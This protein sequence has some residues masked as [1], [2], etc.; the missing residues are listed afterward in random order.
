MSANLR[1]CFPT[2]D[3]ACSFLLSLGKLGKVQMWWDGC[4]L[5]WLEPGNWDKC[6]ILP[7]KLCP[8]TWHSWLPRTHCT[9]LSV[10]SGI[11]RTW[12]SIHKNWGSFA[13]RWFPWRPKAILFSDLVLMPS[14]S[15]QVCTA[16]ILFIWS[17]RSHG[18]VKQW[19]KY[20]RNITMPTQKVQSNMHLLEMPLLCPQ[21]RMQLAY[22][23][24]SNGM[25]LDQVWDK[26]YEKMHINPVPLLKDAG[27]LTCVF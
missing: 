24:N 23:K 18:H 22:V 16:E 4:E 2:S 27:R 7:P 9:N 12:R 15:R 1:P 14:C 25:C 19:S 8:T 6:A 10:P 21:L 13:N 26:G 5:A 20:M 17:M 11:R 3:K